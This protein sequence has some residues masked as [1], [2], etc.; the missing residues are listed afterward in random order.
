VRESPSTESLGNLV[1]QGISN[2][3]TKRYVIKDN[4]S[5]LLDNDTKMLS[6]DLYLCKS[7]HK[8]TKSCVTTRN[9]TTIT[10]V[11]NPLVL[12][13]EEVHQKGAFASD[14]KGSK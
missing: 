4:D 11:R 9:P 1:E 14:L 13:M 3:L 6:H 2:N 8:I 10:L 12:V 7:K 5:I